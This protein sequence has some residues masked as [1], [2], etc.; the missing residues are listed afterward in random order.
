MRSKIIGITVATLVLMALAAVAFGDGRTDG[1]G[2]LPTGDAVRG[3][4]LFEQRCAACHGVDA[5]GTAQG[6]PLIHPFYRPGH[7]ADAAF[8]VA[9][10]R[11]V[12][13][14][15]WN[16][17]PMPAIPDLSEQDIADITR[18]V[19]DLQEAAGIR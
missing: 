11:G 7:H 19:R 10:R 5:G 2:T 6:P 4:A 1:T 18:Y 3:Q 9:V 16:F 13:P 12:T 8:L 15:H 17:G 14:H